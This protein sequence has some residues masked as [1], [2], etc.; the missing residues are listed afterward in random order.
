V[1]AE[2]IFHWALVSPDRAAVEYNDE[3]CSYRIFANAIAAARGE[4]H[5]RGLDSQGYV[6]VAVA[7]LRD[8]WVV[9]LALRS[10]GLATVCV[11]DPAVIPELNLPGTRWVVSSALESLPGLAEVCAEQNL[12]LVATTLEAPPLA[13]GATS[14]PTGGHVLLTSGTTGEYKKVLMDP[15]LEA[16]F[17]LRRLT[18]FPS[19]PDTVANLF[20]FGPW[21]GLG[22]RAPATVWLTGGTVAF[23]QGRPYHFALRRPGLASSPA[24]PA[25]LAEI[26]AAPEGSF[27]RSET[28]ELRIGGGTVTQAQ[29]DQAKA[30]ITPRVFNGLACTESH[31]IAMT[32]QTTPDDHRWHRLE[33]TTVVELVDEFDR[34]T[35][36][37]QTGR[38][39]VGTQDAPTEYLDDEEAT[40]AFFK[41]GFF[42][43]GD[44]AIMRE[45]GR[46]ALQG[47]VTDVINVS[48]QKI[49]PAPI[50]DALREA[51]GVNGACLVSIHNDLGEEG[52][53]LVIEAPTPIPPEIMR[54][55]LAE[56]LRELPPFEAIEV[57]HMPSLPRNANGKLL[58]Q[59]VVRRLRNTIADRR[60]A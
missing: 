25:V 20:D 48:G 55:A 18:V 22:Y 6:V 52:L 2:A 47:R 17:L 36:I 10:L 33:P 39:R 23:S 1:I 4:F 60:P 51:L 44:L 21:T 45:D 37:G 5:R 16:A 42:Y 15:A 13:L 35:P 8:C 54:P 3:P 53:Y 28:M 11:G 7:N 9:T 40:R 58:R 57:G 29:I 19:G 43:P 27:P 50:E 41:D 38:L 32:L 34:P 12:E 31:Q 59:E 49:A 14:H 24:L 46:I 30:R 56:A 26:L